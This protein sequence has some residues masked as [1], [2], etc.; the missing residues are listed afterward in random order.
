MQFQNA[1]VPKEIDWKAY[2]EANEISEEQL[3]KVADGVFV[4]TGVGQVNSKETN[5]AK[6]LSS[7]SNTRDNAPYTAVQ[8]EMFKNADVPSL[9]VRDCTNPPY[10]GQPI[11]GAIPSTL[12]K[13]TRIEGVTTLMWYIGGRLSCTPFHTESRNLP[14]VNALIAGADKRWIVV[15][16]RDNPLLVERFTAYMRKKSKDPVCER[17]LL[18]KLYVLDTSLLDE[19]KIR[20]CIFTQK[21]GDVVLLR[22]AAWHFV[23]NDE[24][25]AAEALNLDTPEWHVQGTIDLPSD[26]CETCKS[27]N[28][29]IERQR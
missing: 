20:Y 14:A 9:Y 13:G 6:M 19:W 28:H 5:V 25:N 27:R 1:F 18:H 7:K 24:L 11:L 17:E 21:Q 29:V 4:K 12:T 16:S 26:G 22:G 10:E 23:S 8:N 3:E 2:I 15:D